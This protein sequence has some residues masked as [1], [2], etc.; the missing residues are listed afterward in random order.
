METV[1]LVLL[2]TQLYDIVHR[3]NELGVPIKFCKEI[4]VLTGK[5]IVVHTFSSA[6]SQK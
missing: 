4:I 3:L 2:L 1:V 6:D 5:E